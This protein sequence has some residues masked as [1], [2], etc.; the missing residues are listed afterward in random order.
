MRHH[1]TGVDVSDLFVRMVGRV[2]RV[3][4]RVMNMMVGV[5][6]MMLMLGRVRVR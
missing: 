4:N 2:D 5:M 3:F 6:N 1:L